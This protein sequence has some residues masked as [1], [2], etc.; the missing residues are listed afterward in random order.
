[1]GGSAFPGGR[2]GRMGPCSLLP[3]YDGSDGR[4]ATNPGVVSRP[5]R[6]TPG[7]GELVA[8]WLPMACPA[9]GFVGDCRYRGRIHC[10]AL[11]SG[12]P[13]IEPETTRSAEWS[14]A[15]CFFSDRQS[16]V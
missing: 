8:F 6:S 4:T 1:M 11:S 13:V 9:M 15:G 3:F 2:I 10:G 12:W 16:V 14:Q 5:A 7:R